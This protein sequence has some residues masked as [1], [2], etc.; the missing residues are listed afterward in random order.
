MKIIGDIMVSDVISVNDT[1]TVH[2]ARMILKDKNIRH[3][4]VIDRQSG[5]F[6][7]LLAQ[8]SLLN[9]AF[10]M[11][12]KYGMTGL[13]KREQRTQVSEIM[14]R[15]C[16]TATPEM[17][18]IQVGELFTDKKLSC[19]PVL[20]GGQLK[21]IVTSVDFVKLALHLLKE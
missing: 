8:G 9:H 16:E 21:G 6:L 15:G 2:H 13:Q 14:D 10:N 12:E 5:G 11:V 1:D 20:E 7:G 19:L 4:P 18:L 17:P 3:L